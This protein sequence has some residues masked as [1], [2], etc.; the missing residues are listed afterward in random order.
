MIYFQVVKTIWPSWSVGRVDEE[1]H[2]ISGS[3]FEVILVCLVSE[4]RLLR[5]RK[6][7]RAF[8]NLMKTLQVSTGTRGSGTV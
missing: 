7:L 2:W 5:A 4:L 6:S 1:D 8:I 3:N